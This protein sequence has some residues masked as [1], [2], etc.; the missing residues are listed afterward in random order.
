[1]KSIN[2]PDNVIRAVRK[3][4]EG[5]EKRGYSV[6]CVY[7]FGSYAKGTWISDSDIDLIVVSDGF[8]DIPFSKRLDIVNDIVW[9]ENIEPYIEALP[10]TLEE[11]ENKT[12]N[13]IVLADASKYWIPLHKIILN[14]KQ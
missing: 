8:K 6:K 7:L 9:K 11:L 14:R 2:I 4:I 13:S 3:F 12:K 5:L 10:Y 1:M